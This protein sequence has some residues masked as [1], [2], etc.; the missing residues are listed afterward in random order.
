MCKFIFIINIELLIALLRCSISSNV[1][2]HQIKGDSKHRRK[3]YAV[4]KNILVRSNGRLHTLSPK[5]FA[6]GDKAI[7]GSLHA[8]SPH[9]ESSSAT[10]TVLPNANEAAVCHWCDQDLPTHHMVAESRP[11][12]LIAPDS[13][14]EVTSSATATVP[15]LSILT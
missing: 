14:H 8:P 15:R 1:S 10:A 5:Q 4:V 6:L 2:V 9:Q 7:R 3:C 12:Q 13:P 11:L